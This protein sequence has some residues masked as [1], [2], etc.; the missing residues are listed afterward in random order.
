MIEWDGIEDSIK[1][2][3]NPYLLITYIFIHKS[4]ITDENLC[5]LVRYFMK[6]HYDLFLKKDMRNILYLLTDYN[7]SSN[8]INDF[9]KNLLKQKELIDLLKIFRNG[10]NRTYFWVK[11]NEDQIK[12]LVYLQ[13][14]FNSYNDCSMGNIHFHKKLKLVEL[15]DEYSQNINVYEIFNRL[16]LIYKLFGC[17]FFSTYDINLLSF[18]DFFDLEYRLKCNYLEY[19]YLEVNKILNDIIDSFKLYVCIKEQ[20][21]QLTNPIPMTIEMD[22]FT[23]EIDDID[24]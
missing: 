13:D 6:Y 22:I 17:K 16:K 10:Y 23:S 1:K 21:N 24:F 7:L 3:E 11:N 14:K 18:D 12:Y 15:E 19:I 5:L 2:T 9:Y 20:M 4:I 8:I